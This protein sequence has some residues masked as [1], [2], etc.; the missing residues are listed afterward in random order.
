MCRIHDNHFRIPESLP[1][2]HDKV[3]AAA[4]EAAMSI[5]TDQKG[6]QVGNC[7]IPSIYMIPCTV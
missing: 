7:L 3:L 2:L 4:A 6:K 5:S 1:C